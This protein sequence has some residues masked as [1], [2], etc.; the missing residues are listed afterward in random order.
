MRAKRKKNKKEG[1]N[2]RNK[3]DNKGPTRTQRIKKGNITTKR[4]Y[5]RKHKK[6]HNWKQTKEVM[7]V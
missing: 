1:M 3:E 4:K 5:Q 7:L 2:D 6:P